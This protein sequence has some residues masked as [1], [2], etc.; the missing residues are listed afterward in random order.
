MWKEDRRSDEEVF[1]TLPCSA[2]DEN[3]EKIGRNRES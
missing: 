1:A 3:Q 2:I